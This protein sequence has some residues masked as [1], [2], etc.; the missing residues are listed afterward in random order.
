MFEFKYST[1]EYYSQG[2]EKVPVTLVYTIPS[3]DV[4]LLTLL[5]HFEEF[6]K[7]A[8]F[9]GVLEEKLISLVNRTNSGL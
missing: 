8:G 1:K 2:G 9:S 3:D 4:G 6:L 7:G 5:E